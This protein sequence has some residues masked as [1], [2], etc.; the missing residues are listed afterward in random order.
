MTFTLQGTSIIGQ[1]RGQGTDLAGYARAAH[2]NSPLDPPYLATTRTELEEACR[3][4]R[5]AFPI[6]SALPAQLRGAFLREIANGLEAIEADLIERI[7]LETALPPARVQAENARTR[8]QLR[9]F[10]D[11]IEEGSWIDARIEQG[12]P[13]R[14]PLPKPELRSMLIPLGPVAVFCAG[15]FP[16]AYSVAGGDTASALAAG[17]PV[18]VNAHH[19]HFGTAE[20]VG[21]V[22]QQASAK[23]GMPPGVFSLIYGAG[24]ELGQLLVQHPAIKAVGFTGSLAG[25]RALADLAA[26]RPNPI[27]VYAEMSSVNPFFILP[28][29]LRE[30]WGD[31]ATGLHASIT[32]GAGQFCTK[33]GLIFVPAGREA[34]QF[35]AKLASLI[36]ATPATTL[37][38]AGIAANYANRR[39]RLSSLA[40]IQTV[41]EGHDGQAALYLTTARA[42]RE[43]GVMH[44]EVFGPAALIIACDGTADMAACAESLAGQLTA[45][46]HAEPADDAAARELL[47]ILASRAGRLIYNGYPTGLEVGPA[48]VHGGPYPATT[49]GRTT[50]VGTAA[51]TR[52]ARPIAFQNLPEAMLPSPIRNANPRGRW[53]LINGQ[54]TRDAVPR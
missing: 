52:W 5:E 49:D 23:T 50:S 26:S 7:G 45:T 48:T 18:I 28:T 42:F 16:L 13:T 37:L 29:A 11:L 20:M 40:T 15:N 8:F 14:T 34:D 17:C 12:D 41:A 39:A 44:E 31:I 51:I 10:A 47:F 30:R 32:N 4:A 27:P 21:T 1:G 36:S 54:L 33:P 22:I 53:R 3:L 6:Y 24:V 38:N 25:G 19:G 35:V 2:D 43:N 46:V 9:M